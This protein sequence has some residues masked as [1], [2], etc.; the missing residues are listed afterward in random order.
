MTVEELVASLE[1]HY[2]NH[3]RVMPWRQSEADG[4]FSGYKILVSEFMLQQTQVSR[5]IP[6]FESFLRKFP[7]IHALAHAEL[8]EVLSEWNGLGYNR[9]A[10]Y[11]H[12][13]A[14]ALAKLPEPWTL[15]LLAAQKGIGPNT[16]AAVLV[17]AYNIPLLFVETNIRTVI[18]HSFYRDQEAVADKDILAKLAKVQKETTLM[19]REFYWALMDYG[20]HLKATVGNLNRRSKQYAR[21]SKFEGSRRQVRGQ[22]IR[23]LTV[24]PKSLSQL[25][26]HIADPRLE[27]VLGILVREKLLKFQEGC[28][29]LYNDSE[30]P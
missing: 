5:V 26:A 23:M 2:K 14:R 3:A 30:K 20:T 18:I 8:S 22:V 24:E 10:K 6:K 27:D 21:Q 25:R 28:F 4:S 1:T 29:M 13:A 12:E 15:E 17:Y 7:D 11:L 19:P 16:A 9:R